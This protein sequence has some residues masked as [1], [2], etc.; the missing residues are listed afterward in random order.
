MQAVP[1]FF[2]SFA[3]KKESI[4]LYRDYAHWISLPFFFFYLPPELGD[5][6]KII[7]VEKSAINGRVYSQDAISIAYAIVQKKL[8]IYAFASLVIRRE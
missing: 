2:S 6:P 7:V 8:R 5:A 3:G 1:S 4:S